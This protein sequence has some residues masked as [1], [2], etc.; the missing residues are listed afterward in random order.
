L[1]DS[2]S[3]CSTEDSI[4]LGI[5]VPACAAACLI[6]NQKEDGAV[7]DWSVGWSLKQRT[8]IIATL[9]AAD[10]PLEVPMTMLV[11]KTEAPWLE[12]NFDNCD[13]VP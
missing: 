9:R 4:P 10:G 1:K 3:N 5:F 12:Y 8:D 6:S 2:L 11:T 7:D 13:E